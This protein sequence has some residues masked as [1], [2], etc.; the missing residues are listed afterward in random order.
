[1]KLFNMMCLTGVLIGFSLS[2]VAAQTSKPEPPKPD[3]ASKVQT[4]PEK[5][6]AET[7][8]IVPVGPPAKPSAEELN[9]KAADL[10]NSGKLEESA[11]AYKQVNIAYPKDIQGVVGLAN[12]YARMKKYDE[13][14]AAYRKAI[15][16]N[17][18]FPDFYAG[19]ATFY[20][21]GKHYDEA[22][23][24]F[25]GAIQ[26]NPKFPGYYAGLGSSYLE[27][28][29]YD[30]A[31]HAY[32]RAIELKPDDLA[33]RLSLADVNL[34]ARD[35]GQARTALMEALGFAPDSGA[36]HNA[37]G[38]LDEQENMHTD[39]LEEFETSLRINP[40]DISASIGKATTLAGLKRLPEAEQLL[41]GLI[42]KAPKE[43][44]LL[45][46]LAQAM[47]TGGKHLEAISEY[48]A[49]IILAPIDPYL[50]GNLGWAQYNAK[51]YDESIK[52]GRKA[53]LLESKLPYVKFN[54]GLT[55]AVQDRWNEAEKEYKEALKISLPGDIRSGISDVRDAIS[56]LP[57]VKSLKQSL[58]FLTVSEWKALGISQP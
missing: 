18:T 9:K 23:K 31:G 54:L 11:A 2:I 38:N 1:M 16:L 57:K 36:V 33:L 27:A 12:V 43:P 48:Q 47:D 30:E 53:L 51:Q 41:R 5:S 58:D 39:A 22:A 34:R 15:E 21:L 13:G 17:P 19:L 50:W 35:Y 45:S 52:S 46:S 8:K 44:S 6:K 37:L 40:A 20:G 56:R 26:L 10:F 49:A 7:A 4:A 3:A 24:A 42:A 32:Q 55:F 29:K 25:E 28:E 14:A